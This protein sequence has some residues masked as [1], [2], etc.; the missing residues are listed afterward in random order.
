MLAEV[1]GEVEVLHLLL[2][3]L[4]VVEMEHLTLAPKELQEL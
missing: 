2:V 4:V 1:E 3:V